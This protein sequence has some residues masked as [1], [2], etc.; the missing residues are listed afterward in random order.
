MYI[1]F[2]GIL[3]CRNY[4]VLY[5]PATDY[6][7]HYIPLEQMYRTNCT[8][9]FQKSRNPKNGIITNFSA[10]HHLTDSLSIVHHSKN[11][12]SSTELRFPQ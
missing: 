2:H 11:Y 8:S 5:C 4:G 12:F 9:T 1:K 10:S 6:Y 3:K 7:S